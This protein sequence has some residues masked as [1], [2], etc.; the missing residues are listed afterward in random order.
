ML[1]KKI[2]AVLIL[3]LAVFVLC[4]MPAGAED[5]VQTYMIPQDI[6]VTETASS[7]VVSWT[8]TDGASEYLVEISL[9]SDGSGLIIYSAGE[10]ES[11]VIIND[12]TEGTKYCIR[13]KAVYGEN[14]SEWTETL[15]FKTKLFTPLLRSYTETI[16]A[17]EYD[18]GFEYSEGGEV[19]QKSNVFT[20]LAEHTEYTFYRKRMGE[21]DVSEPLK[22]ITRCTHSVSHTDRN[23]P[24]CTSDGSEKLICD[25]CGETVSSQTIKM[26]PHVFGDEPSS[27]TAATELA[28]GSKTY[29]CTVCGTEK[30]EIV[31][32]TGCIHANA[33]RKDI[34]AASCTEKGLYANVCEDCG[35]TVDTVEEDVLPHEE[36]EPLT[37]VEPTC[38]TEGISRTFCLICGETLSEEM[39]GMTPHVFSEK[40]SDSDGNEIRHC[41]DCGYVETG[42]V[43]APKN[44]SDSAGITAILGGGYYFSDGITFSASDITSQYKET[45][46]DAV[47]AINKAR[48]NNGIATVYSIAVYNNGSEFTSAPV[49]VRIPT[50]HFS[51]SVFSVFEILP[52][53][54]ATDC[55]AA[56]SGEYIIF[57]KRSNAAYAIVDTTGISDTAP[58]KISPRVL[59]ISG[60][61][62]VV[63]FLGGAGFAGYYMY[64]KF[65]NKKSREW[66]DDNPDMNTKQ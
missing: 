57:I 33:S 5:D 27:Q 16:I 6:S 1:L 66:L 9:Q 50:A 20:G 48:K 37:V 4:V 38:I 55:G 62:A 3:C 58:G 61:V 32:K 44:T 10:A 23:E 7:A 51:G 65:R 35:A 18:E 45:Y 19:W 64:S 43:I 60:I 52:D 25:I 46:A 42:E 30:T 47:S 12:L 2:F 63:I 41:L 21:T 22:I 31:A 15:E 24:T 14:E 8:G 17:L 53:G 49:S 11:S 59:I 26:I 34:T 54:T 39:I 40:Y 29:V 36:S 13:V 56:V 28:S